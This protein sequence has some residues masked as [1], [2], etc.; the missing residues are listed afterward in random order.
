MKKLL[1]ILSG[2]AFSLLFVGSSWATWCQPGE[3]EDGYYDQTWTDGPDSYSLWSAGDDVTVTHDIT[4]DGYNPGSDYVYSATLYIN[5][6]GLDYD[7][8][9]KVELPPAGPIN[10]VDVYFWNANQTITL[11]FYNTLDVGMDGVFSYYVKNTSFDW[12]CWDWDNFCFTSTLEADGCRPVPEP[13][14]M[15]LFGTGLAGLAGASRRRKK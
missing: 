1:A 4:D 9:A 14:T 13:A 3:C 2:L 5:F 11:G 7:E 12:D 15:L 10:D 6:H 8:S